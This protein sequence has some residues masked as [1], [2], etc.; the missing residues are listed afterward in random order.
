MANG[1]L[2]NGTYSQ[3]EDKKIVTSL[4]KLANGLLIKWTPY[5]NY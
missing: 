3:V 1:V 5:A 2:S 4:V